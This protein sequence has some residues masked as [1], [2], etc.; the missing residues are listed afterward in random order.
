MPNAVYATAAVAETK[1]ACVSGSENYAFAVLVST[2]IRLTE[3]L[4]VGFC[5]G[6]SLFVRLG[7]NQGLKDERCRAV[8]SIE[9][10]FKDW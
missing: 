9:N 2:N 3:K 5:R 8:N 4:V 7:K 6:D 10:G 1:C